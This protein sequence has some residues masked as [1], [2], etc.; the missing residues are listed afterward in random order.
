MDA[1]IAIEPSATKLVAGGGAR[2]P[3]SATSTSRRPAPTSVLLNGRA[4]RAKEYNARK[5]DYDRVIATY[6]AVNERIQQDPTILR[7]FA[8]QMGFKASET[9][10]IELLPERLKDVYPTQFGAAERKNL[11]DQIAEAV[12]LGLLQTRPRRRRCTSDGDRGRDR[13][14]VRSAGARPTHAAPASRHGVAGARA[15]RRARRGR[16]AAVGEHVE[17]RADLDVG[18]VATS[19]RTILREGGALGELAVTIERVVLGFALAFVVALAAGIAMGRNAFAAAFLEPA[20]LLGLTIPGLVWALLCVIWFGVALTAPVV[21]IALSAAP[22]LVLNV[23]QGMRAVDPGLIE[24]AH[25]FRF[26]RLTRLRRLWLPSLAPFLLS[27]G[28][29]RALPVVEGDRARGD[30]RDVERRRLPAQPVLQRAG[31]RRRAGVDAAVRGW[32]WG[33]SSTACCGRSSGA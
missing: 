21:A 31:R 32:R 18:D 17:Q 19:L 30:V 1:I 3:A 6:T 22:A 23:V 4:V 20:V 28:A 16:L 25:V 9:K 15:V 13:A 27:G 12:K 14:H 29:A 7:Q 2:S 11:D 10:A 33:C 8:T 5:A 26:D 24:M